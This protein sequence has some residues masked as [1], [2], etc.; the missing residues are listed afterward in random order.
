MGNA[1]QEF[2]DIRQ[3]AISVLKNLMIKHSLDD[4]YVSRVSVFSEAFLVT[5]SAEVFVTWVL[6]KV[7]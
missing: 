6:R 4:R 7:N 1:L 3:I 2:R 5:L